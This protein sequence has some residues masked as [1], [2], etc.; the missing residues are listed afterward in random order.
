MRLLLVEHVA[1][2]NADERKSAIDALIRCEPDLVIG[3]LGN[4][5]TRKRAAETLPG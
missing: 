3:L 5:G 1:L 4:S 2:P